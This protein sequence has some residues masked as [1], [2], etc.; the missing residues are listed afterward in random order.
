[1]RRFKSNR[2][3]TLILALVLSVVGVE[4][5]PAV[6]IADKGTDGTI[7]NTGTDGTIPPN[8]QGAGDP[9][10]PSGSGKSSV[11]SGGGWNYGT[12]G[13]FGVGDAS[14]EPAAPIKMRVRLALG[15]LK[16][17]YLRF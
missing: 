14:V 16:Y 12:I 3:W 5:L 7:G 17:F 11:K 2:W 15:M 9:D 1:M 4:L 6:G 13:T 8:P 10:S